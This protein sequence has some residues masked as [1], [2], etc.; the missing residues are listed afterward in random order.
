[1][2]EFNMEFKRTPSGAYG[3]FINDEVQWVSGRDYYR[4]GSAFNHL[5]LRM[6]P[7][8]K[9]P[10][11]WKNILVIGGGDFQLISESNFLVH[12]SPITVVDPNVTAYFE[13]AKIYKEK[14]KTVFN[15]QYAS[16][17]RKSFLNVIERPIQE[18][19]ER[20][21]KKRASSKFDLIVL[22]L[23]DDISVDENNTF[24]SKI[25]YDMLRPNGLIVGYGG[26]DLTKFMSESP[27]PLFDIEDF[28]VFKEYFPSWDDYGVFYGARKCNI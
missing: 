14:F 4:Y 8:N 19:V 24:M 11:A 5:Y 18:Y 9:Y 7:D 13:L 12:D 21:N 1:M 10:K 22:D 25:F 15:R 23:T 20:F 16:Y 2:T 6:F 27:I 17:T 3:Y 28:H 26:T